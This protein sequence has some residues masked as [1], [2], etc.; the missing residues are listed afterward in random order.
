MLAT[1]SQALS[2][3]I[4]NVV[5]PSMLGTLGCINQWGAGHLL[6][7][8]ATKSFSF[9]QTS[10]SSSILIMHTVGAVFLYRN[11][12]EA[13]TRVFH[14]QRL[15]MYISS[16]RQIPCA[17]ALAS[18]VQDFFCPISGVRRGR[19]SLVDNIGM[20]MNNMKRSIASSG[21]STALQPSQKH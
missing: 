19:E 3:T 20:K 9:L 4:A 16:F 10:Q 18:Q 13:I 5:L 6:P 15:I 17:A 8:S 1:V 12:E 21:A 2:I 14:R 7:R 11:Q